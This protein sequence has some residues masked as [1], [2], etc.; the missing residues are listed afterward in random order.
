MTEVRAIDYP[1]IPLPCC[2]LAPRHSHC[3]RVRR[4]QA[5]LCHPV[6]QPLCRCRWSL[7]DSLSGPAQSRE[8]GDHKKSATCPCHVYNLTV[9]IAVADFL[10]T[11]YRISFLRYCSFAVLSSS[12]HCPTKTGVLIFRNIYLIMAD[13]SGHDGKSSRPVRKSKQIAEDMRLAM[14]MASQ[15]SRQIDKAEKV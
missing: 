7:A 10:A 11:L 15:L 5:T 12:F 1:C 13:D 14:M 6:Q 8:V 2:S 3:K 9:N 4:A